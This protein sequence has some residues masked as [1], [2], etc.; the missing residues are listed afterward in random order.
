MS[1]LCERGQE[2][3]QPEC[4]EQSWQA[5]GNAA[6]M[7]LGLENSAHYLRNFYFQGLL[8]GG[9]EKAQSVIDAGVRSERIPSHGL[10]TQ[11]DKAT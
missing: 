3:S 8:R 5:C 10:E 4:P 6:S 2:K 1:G 11:M 7:K 9:N